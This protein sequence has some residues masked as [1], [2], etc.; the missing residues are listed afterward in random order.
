MNIDLI[1]RI[2]DGDYYGA[3]IGTAFTREY[4][5]TAA[6]HILGYVGPITR[7][8]YEARQGQGYSLNATVGKTGVEAAFEEYL[9]GTSGTRLSNT[10]D[11]GK[12]TSELYTVEPQPG[13]TVELTLDLPFQEAVE[14]L[15][16]DKV[17]ELNRQ[18][19]LTERGAAA[20]VID[21][22]SR[23]ILAIASA[24]TYDLSNFNKIITNTPPTRPTPCGTGPP[25]ASTPPAP[26]SSPRRPSPP[27]RRASPPPASGFTTR[28]NGSTPAIPTA[29]PIAG[30]AAATAR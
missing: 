16:N 9:H 13:N 25:G 21:I 12:V 24:P 10:N 11:E 5:T 30:S 17:D 6:A 3:D 28:V 20:V 26:P 27:W 19:G 15:L 7:E 4:E 14:T 18:D 1:T 8:E 22:E 23:D 2:K 29:T